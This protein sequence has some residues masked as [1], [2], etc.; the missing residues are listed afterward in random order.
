MAGYPK[1]SIVCCWAV[2]GKT[3]QHIK[4]SHRA[5]EKINFVVASLSNLVLLKRAIIVHRLAI[6]P[7][8]L[9]IEVITAAKIA[10]SYDTGIVV[11]LFAIFFMFLQ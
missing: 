7:T 3:R 9:N 4:K 5:K 10:T 11:S 2:G 6:V 1:F 8:K